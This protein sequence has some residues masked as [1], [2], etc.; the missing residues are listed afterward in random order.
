MKARMWG[1]ISGAVRWL[2]STV[3]YVLAGTLFVGLVMLPGLFGPFFADARFSFYQFEARLGSNPLR[4]FD[5][6][7]DQI[8]DYL[9]RGNF[10]PVSR[11]QYGLEYWALFK[12]SYLTGVPGHILHAIPKLAMV[13]ALLWVVNGITRQYARASATMTSGYWKVLRWTFVVALGVFL[14]L[15]SPTQ[16]PMMLFPGL[17]VGGVVTALAVTALVG[18]TT[19]TDRASRW[20]L[21]LGAVLGALIAMMIE[22]A[23]VA[24][25]LVVGHLVLL[26]VARHGWRGALGVITRSAGLRMTV[27]VIGGFAVVFAP[28]RVIIA[29]ICSDGSC[30]AASAPGIDEDT[31]GML[32]TRFTSPILMIGE[33]LGRYPP[34]SVGTSRIVAAYAVLVCGIGFLLITQAVMRRSTTNTTV[35]RSWYLLGILALGVWLFGAAIGALSEGLEPGR[36]SAWRDT[37]ILWPAAALTTAVVVARL[38]AIRKPSGIVVSALLVTVLFSPIRMNDRIMA[39]T[40]ADPI[41]V[42]HMRVD[43]AMARFDESPQGRRHR[44]RLLKQL[45]ARYDDPSSALDATLVLVDIASERAHGESYCPGSPEVARARRNRN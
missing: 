28:V 32:A 1:I 4:I 38:I 24:V 21:I 9:D 41:N 16:H 10:R 7:I 12:T 40:V 2:D 15:L 8:P 22:L 19:L 27:S 44:C 6:V 18:R 31:L 37:A 42:A 3:G 39:T 5:F 11:I 36:E 17:Y 34:G 33:A 20:M 13:A 43:V 29:R 26:L 25:P 23:Y 14:V 45:V 35:P 30:Y